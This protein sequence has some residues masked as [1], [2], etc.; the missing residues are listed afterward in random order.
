MSRD[1]IAG[2]DNMANLSGLAGVT[3]PAQRLSPSLAVQARIERTKVQAW[4]RAM[5]GHLVKGTV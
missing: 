3:K 4:L 1:M 2:G 5:I